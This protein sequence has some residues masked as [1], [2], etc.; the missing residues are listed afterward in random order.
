MRQRDY[1]HQHNLSVAEFASRIGISDVTAWRY[2]NGRVP[3]P[4]VLERIIAATGGAVTPND[5]FDVS[6]IA[7]AGGDAA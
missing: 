5:Y 2:E 3:D 6:G 1:R 7:S 4:G